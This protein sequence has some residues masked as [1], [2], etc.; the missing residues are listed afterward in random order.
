MEAEAPLP[1][2]QGRPMLRRAPQV[3]DPPLPAVDDAAGFR[4]RGGLALRLAWIASVLAILLALGAM[5]T[6]RYEIADAWP[7][8]SRLTG[9]P[10]G[11]G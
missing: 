1:H 3:I 10:V 4:H 11:G 7:P 8:A 2:P 9:S 5:W 6:F